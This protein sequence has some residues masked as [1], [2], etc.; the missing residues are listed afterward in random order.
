MKKALFILILLVLSLLYYLGVLTKK[1]TFPFSKEFFSIETSTLSDQPID[2][3]GRRASKDS[4][5]TSKDLDQLYQ[6]K[7]DKGIRNIPLLSLLLIRQA[8]ES[9]NSGDADQSVQWARYSVK[10]SPD[11][12][13]PYFDLARALWHQNPL[14]FLRPLSE[15]WKGL[16]AYF[17][18]YPRAL[19]LFCNLF[20][21]L[22]NALLMT[23]IVFAVVG[24]VKYLPL[25]FYDIHKNLSQEMGKLLAN[26]LKI[27]VLFI[28][29]FLRIDLLWALLFY[30]ILLWGFVTKRERQ[31]IVFFFVVLVYLPFFLRSASTFLNGPASGILMEMNEANYEAGGSDVRE[32]L[33]NWLS[34]HP[35][36][37]EVIFT[38]GLME[39]RQGRYPQAEEYYR[40]AIQLSP[41]FSGAY[42]N[43]GN[44]YFARKQTDL[45]IASYQRAIE[46]DPSQGAYFYNLYRAYSQETFLSVKKDGAFQKAR[47]LDPNLVE[48]Y[49][50]IDTPPHAN[51]LVVDEVLGPN[52][53]WTRF[54]H[55]FVGRE[56]ILFHLFKAWFEKIPSRIFFL[57]PLFF[58]GFWVGMSK[59][60][61]TRR[62]LTRCP[63]C[64]SPTHRFYLGNTDQEYIC[65]NCYRIY[66]QREKLHPK[67]AEKKAVQVQQFQKENDFVQRFLSFFF[68]GFKDLWG[69]HSFKGISL[70]FVFFVFVLRFVHWDGVIPF[71]FGQPLPS[72]WKW[73]FWVGLFGLYY[74][75]ALG[76]VLRAGAKS[77]SKRKLIAVR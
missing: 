34:T 36:D 66:I 30:L 33:K 12:P 41:S 28:P 24:L 21:V 10:F 45:A 9:R 2:L 7:L 14:Q 71:S 40:K 38:L 57:A 15:A 63:M 56:G 6:Q 65:F 16:L 1:E 70:L 75:V 31:F 48:Y 76:P 35:D 19:R 17:R 62:F 5:L 23:F 18:Y 43:F 54:Y 22:G 4:S 20:Y 73:I 49:S 32:R 53:L 52:A 37:A 55:Q 11:L 74:Y 60:G 51:R 67:I 42:S 68:L 3:R 69:D 72:L 25:Y 46:L 8:R 77:A 59:Y 29:F 39:K 44:V 27:F 13:E 61:R 26:S 58:L 64:G 50:S 47:Q